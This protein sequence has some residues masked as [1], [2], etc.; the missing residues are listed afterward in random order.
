L[1]MMAGRLGAWKESEVRVD[2]SL[3]FHNLFFTSQS[4]L[5]VSIICAI[6]NFEFSRNK[7]LRIRE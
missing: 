7:V 6:D 1:A 2:N 3:V 4:A 5:R